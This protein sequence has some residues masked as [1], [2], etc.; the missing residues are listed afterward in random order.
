MKA[1]ARGTNSAGSDL[2]AAR[3]DYQAGLAHVTSVEQQI[4]LTPPGGGKKPLGVANIVS[5]D[6]Q[7]ALAVVGQDLAPSGHYVL[8]L[9]NGSKVKFLG[10]FPVVT[11]T[12][13]NKGRLQGLVAAPSDLTSYK[14]LLV[15]R[16]ASSTPKTPS[17]TILKGLIDG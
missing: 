5:Q 4:N 15:T 1:R 7:R 3:E 2:R 16:E 6:G 10:F 12:G 9:R 8:W 13:T 11:A 17:A 14:E